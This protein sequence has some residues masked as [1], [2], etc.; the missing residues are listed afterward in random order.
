MSFK[1]WQTNGWLKP[2]TP[3]AKEI[4]R[5]FDVV[6]RDL[7][8]GNDGHTD[9]DWRFVAAYNAALQCCAIALYA[10]GYQA[11]K[12]GGAHHYTIESLK[13][14]IQ[15]DGTSIDELQA[16]KSK[17]GGAV[18]EM[19]G[20]ASETEITQLCTLAMNLRDRVRAWLRHNHPQLLT[21][22]KK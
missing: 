14:T 3:D 9:P 21:K 8:V 22:G 5:L 13:L 2:H 12:G 7:R 18:Y 11:T 17:R 10:S 16:F 19:T 15:D 20:I 4:S 1:D 6:E